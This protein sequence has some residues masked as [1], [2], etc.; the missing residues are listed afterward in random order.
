MQT[1]LETEVGRLKVDYE[2][3]KEEAISLQMQLKHEVSYSFEWNNFM[4]FNTFI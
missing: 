3:A 2:S 4:D 1:R